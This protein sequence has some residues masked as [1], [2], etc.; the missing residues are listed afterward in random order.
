MPGNFT[1]LPWTRWR[2]Y[3]PVQDLVLCPHIN[4]GIHIGMGGV[5]LLRL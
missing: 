4:G 1:T 5:M 2:I 3:H